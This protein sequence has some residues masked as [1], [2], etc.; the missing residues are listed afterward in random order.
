MVE[1]YEKFSIIVSEMSAKKV[2]ISFD[3]YQRM[4]KTV[5]STPV[6]EKS[7]GQLNKTRKT[8]ENHLNSVNFFH[9]DMMQIIK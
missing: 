9:F 7:E 6:K 8:D 5:K 3:K 1:N 4:L 2:V